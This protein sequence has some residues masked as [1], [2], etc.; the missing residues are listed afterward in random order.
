MLMMHRQFFCYVKNLIFV[1]FVF[2][3][4]DE[5]KVD[6]MKKEQQSYKS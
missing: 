3:Y 6:A 4:R 1:N 5:Y 2:L